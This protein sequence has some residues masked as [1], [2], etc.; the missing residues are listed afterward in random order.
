MFL[1]YLRAGSRL[2]PDGCRR[3]M[4]FYKC[5]K[6]EMS[7]EVRRLKMYGVITLKNGCI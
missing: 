1:S 5:A 4:T 7:A 3:W 6:G 2:T